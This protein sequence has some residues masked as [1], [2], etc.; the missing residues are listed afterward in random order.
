[1]GRPKTLNPRTEGKSILVTKSQSEKL[2][3]IADKRD[4]S[5]NYIICE[6]IEN[7]L[8]RTL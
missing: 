7:Y 3:E 6:A 5:V 8:A 1:M 4:R 2:K